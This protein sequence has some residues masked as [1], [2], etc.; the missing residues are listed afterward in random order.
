M[1]TCTS[2]WMAW[3]PSCWC[4]TCQQ[5][6]SLFCDGGLLCGAILQWS[7]GSCLC[8]W[9]YVSSIPQW[10]SCQA[11][12]DWLFRVNS[13]RDRSKSSSATTAVSCC[14]VQQQHHYVQ[15][16]AAPQASDRNNEV[17]LHGQD[18]V[19]LALGVSAS[20][21]TW[22][23][24]YSRAPPRCAVWQAMGNSVKKLWLFGQPA[25]Q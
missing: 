23:N 11:P 10:Y 18:I 13:D 5:Q 9:W 15:C 17:A 16:P 3:A 21:G 12:L 6:I 22:G 24:S 4:L 8:L 20:V 25:W 14:N 1:P 2:S 19:H 7:L